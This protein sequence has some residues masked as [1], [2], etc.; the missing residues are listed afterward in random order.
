[1]AVADWSTSANSNTSIDGINIAE[2]CPAGNLNGAVRAIMA[3]VRVMYDGLPTLADYVKKDGTTDFTGQ[4]KFTGRGGFLHHNNPANS[5]GRV[6]VQASG[7]P[8]PSMANG[9]ILMEF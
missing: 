1:M 5:S 4:P 8:V 6:F 3:N 2:N 9:D 7:S